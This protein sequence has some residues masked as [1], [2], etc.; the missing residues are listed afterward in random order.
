MTLRVLEVAEGS[1]LGGANGLPAFQTRGH[2][3]T[4]APD[5]ERERDN[6]VP[7]LGQLGIAVRPIVR[8][9]LRALGYVD[10][11]T[12][13]TRILALFDRAIAHAT[14][15][16]SG[17]T[18]VYAT[19]APKVCVRLLGGL[20]EIRVDTGGELRLAPDATGY[21]GKSVARVDDN[22]NAVASLTAWF[23]AANVKLNTIIPMTPMPVAPVTIGTIST[24]APAVKA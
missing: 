24:G 21:Q 8:R 22:V 5:A 18:R 4:G 14:A 12:D 20:I 6:D 7:F 9:S 23:T 19:G 16:A 11:G 1:D 13:E 10:R 3:T 17:E 2:G 15:V